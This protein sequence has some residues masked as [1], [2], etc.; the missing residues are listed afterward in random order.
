MSTKLIFAI[1]GCL[2]V[3]GVTVFLVVHLV[4]M[5]N[6][7]ETQ[8]TLWHEVETSIVMEDGSVSSTETAKVVRDVINE[9]EQMDESLPEDADGH[10]LDTPDVNDD[11]EL[12]ESSTDVPVMDLNESSTELN[13]IS[14]TELMTEETLKYD[15]SNTYETHNTDDD[16]AGGVYASKFG[17]IVAPITCDP[18]RRFDPISRKCKLNI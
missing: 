2:L 14:V 7:L 18:P 1:C 15:I 17:V 13:N 6:E 16:P 8:E 3:A 4:V 11:K 5:R 10:I 9:N 12:N